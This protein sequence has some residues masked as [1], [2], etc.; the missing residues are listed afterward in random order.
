MPFKNQDLGWIRVNFKR[1]A[2]KALRDFMSKT[3]LAPVDWYEDLDEETKEAYNKSVLDKTT[4][5]YSAIYKFSPEEEQ[6]YRDRFDID[7]TAYI[8]DPI[9]ANEL[10]K[11]IMK[12]IQELIGDY[13]WSDWTEKMG[14][15][16]NIDQRKIKSWALFSDSILEKVYQKVTKEDDLDYLWNQMSRKAVSDDQQFAIDYFY[17]YRKMELGLPY[18]K[19]LIGSMEL[20]KTTE[21]LKEAAIGFKPD[22]TGQARSSIETMMG[23]LDQVMDYLQGNAFVKTYESGDAAKIKELVNKVGDDL[24][25]LLSIVHSTP[26]TK[27][28][29]MGLKQEIR[30][31]NYKP[32]GEEMDL[33]KT[34][35]DTFGDKSE[36]LALKQLFFASPGKAMKKLFG[37]DFPFNHRKEDGK[38]V[39]G[40]EGYNPDGTLFS[41]KDVHKEKIIK[42]F[43]E[44]MPSADVKPNM[45]GGITVHLKESVNEASYKVAGRSVDLIKGKKSDGTDWKVKFKNGKEVALADVLALI[46]PF[47]KGITKE[48]VNKAKYRVEYTTQ[49]G[50]KAKSRVYNSEEEADKKEADLVNSGI[51]QA[52]VVKV[53]ESVNEG[54]KKGQKVTY[55]GHPGVITGVYD[56]GGKKIKGDE[57]PHFVSVSYDKGIGKTKA[58][59]ILATDGTVKPVNENI[60]TL[61]SPED[62]KY[63]RA[64][65]EEIEDILNAEWRS[66]KLSAKDAVEKHK[67]MKEGT[68]GYNTDAKTGKKFKTPGGLEERIKT[69]V[70]E[71]TK[72]K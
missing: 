69:L 24:N 49:D 2:D 29:K 44:K 32:L 4:N 55:L 30:L 26:D 12:F 13:R 40:A 31:K 1:E 17:N 47:P 48:S 38:I 57:V 8:K 25:D 6:A 21:Q 9:A 67:A 37:L 50:E 14:L 11:A 60:E 70:K 63:Y 68:C 36:E 54:F 19:E 5:T 35:A 66:S 46:K 52:K 41:M 28:K 7:Y 59:M 53:E 42:T 71:F 34:W 23:N 22:A 65:R 64:H 43:Q 27:A 15:T 33:D 20:D 51:K 10:H 39:I 61:L 58:Y 18:N 62:L 45:G 72:Q 16:E 3:N 56:R